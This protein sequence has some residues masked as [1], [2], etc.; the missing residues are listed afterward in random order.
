MVLS[1]VLI[2]SNLRTSVLCL[3]CSDNTADQNFP[4]FQ[5]NAGQSLIIC[6]LGVVQSNQIFLSEKEL[7]TEQ[8]LSSLVWTRFALVYLN[9]P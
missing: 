5:T 9:L 3:L 7:D 2:E 8:H 6:G 1:S 4:K